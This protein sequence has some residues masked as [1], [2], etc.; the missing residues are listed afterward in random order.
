MGSGIYFAKNF[1]VAAKYS[2]LPGHISDLFK[3]Q[4]EGKSE[5]RRRRYAF[6]CEVALGKSYQVYRKDYK[7]TEPPSGY[8][9]CRS[10]PLSEAN[11]QPSDFDDEEFC[12]YNIRQQRLAYIIEFNLDSEVVALGNDPVPMNFNPEDNVNVESQGARLKRIRAKKQ[13]ISNLLKKIDEG[14][15]LEPVPS[16]SQQPSGLITAKGTDRL[17]L[18]EVHIRGNILDLVAE[19]VLFQRY[20]NFSNNSV[21]LLFIYYRLVLM[22]L[23]SD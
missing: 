5:V 11:D 4:F 14:K 8:Q 21:S 9:S 10:V 22:F 3:K 19:V 7:M 17:P 23:C 20:K 6:V 13:L 16:L 1:H 12:I 15:Q 2:K 18:Q